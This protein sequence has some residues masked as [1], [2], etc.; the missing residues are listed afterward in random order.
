MPYCV[1][2]E[3]KN[4]T[5]FDIYCFRQGIIC[6]PETSAA[7]MG[8]SI[9]R[10]SNVPEYL[11]SLSGKKETGFGLK[12]LFLCRNC[13]AVVNNKRISNILGPSAFFSS[14]HRL[15][16][17]AMGPYRTLYVEMERQALPFSGGECHRGA[18]FRSG[19]LRSFQGVRKQIYQTIN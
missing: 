15:F 8:P 19:C 3:D 18:S 11:L 14:S 7:L 10:H 1:L 4:T 17:P 13:N 9:L 5:Y 2:T 16:Q 6:L 12:R